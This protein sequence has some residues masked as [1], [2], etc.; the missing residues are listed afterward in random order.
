MIPSHT[1]PRRPGTPEVGSYQRTSHGCTCCN[2]RVITQV[3]IITRYYPNSPI[4]RYFF[5]DLSTHNA[6]GKFYPTYYFFLEKIIK[7]PKKSKNQFLKNTN[8]RNLFKK[9]ATVML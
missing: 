7:S 5:S 1:T 2:P 3:I 8:L 6:E 9:Y 4:F